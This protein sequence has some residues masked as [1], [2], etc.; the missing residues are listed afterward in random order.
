MGSY[1]RNWSVGGS[2]VLAAEPSL[3]LPIMT[4]SDDLLSHTELIENMEKVMTTTDIDKFLEVMQTRPSDTLWDTMVDT[5]GYTDGNIYTNHLMDT[6]W[7]ISDSETTSKLFTQAF[8][9]EMPVSVTDAGWDVMTN[10][11]HRI[12]NY[13]NLANYSSLIDQPWLS[14]TLQDLEAGRMS[15]S[16]FA[17]L[18]LEQ[19]EIVTQALFYHL[20]QDSL[21]ELFA[22]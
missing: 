1:L 13:D 15:V 20:P 7:R 21:Q 9:G 10:F 5:F 17:D 14:Q 8:R 3:I 4:Q 2:T 18:P 11:L 22:Q 16:E 6:W 19:R 12:Y